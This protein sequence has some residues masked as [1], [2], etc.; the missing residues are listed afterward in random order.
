MSPKNTIRGVSVAR[1][2]MPGRAVG[3]RERGSAAPGPMRCHDRE[4]GTI[5]TATTAEQP[6]GSDGLD[7]R[8]RSDD[9]SRPAQ[10]GPDEERRRGSPPDRSTRRGP[11]R[12]RGSRNV[13]SS[14]AMRSS[15]A[16]R[17]AARLLP[18]QAERARRGRCADRGGR[19]RSRSTSGKLCSQVGSWITTGT[20][21]QRCSTAASHTSLDGGGMKSESTKTNVPGVTARVCAARC[22]IERSSQSGGPPYSDDQRRS[23]RS[24]ISF[25]SPFGCRQCGSPSA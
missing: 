13:S 9:P 20:M 22:S 21:S 19:R 2:S 5:A 6:R 24:S 10:V 11:G 23:S 18:A 1:A 17:R 12:C 7:S 14:S 8:S 3:S 15:L 25:R 16:L 4:R